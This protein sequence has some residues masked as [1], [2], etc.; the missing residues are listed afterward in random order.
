MFPTAECTNCKYEAGGGTFVSTVTMTPLLSFLLDHGIN[1]ISPDT[2]DRHEMNRVHEEY[3]EEILNTDPLT[4]RFTTTV[5]GDEFSLTTDEELN[6][7]DVSYPR[8]GA[9]G[10]H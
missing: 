8:R 2:A 3:S 10:P 5:D 1:P 9:T 6:V 4:V 7:I